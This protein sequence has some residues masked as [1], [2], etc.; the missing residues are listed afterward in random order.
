MPVGQFRSWNR[1]L[2]RVG[3]ANQ[4]GLRAT[5]TK[6]ELDYIDDL[7]DDLER[8]GVDRLRF[9]KVPMRRWTTDTWSLDVAGAPVRT[10]VVHP[11]LRRRRPRRA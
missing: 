1:A 10:V 5:G 6:A 2:D 11:L 7:R 8:A 4:R 9:E 3:P